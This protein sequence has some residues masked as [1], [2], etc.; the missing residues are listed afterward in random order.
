MDEEQGGH[1]EEG[2]EWSSP[3]PRSGGAPPPSPGACP[4]E[5]AL[6]SLWQG[7]MARYGQGSN[8]PVCWKAAPLPAP[9]PLEGSPTTLASSTAFHTWKTV[10]AVERMTRASMAHITVGCYC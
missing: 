8:S 4:W 1:L 7:A 5:A 10:S 6:E 2:E 3:A 9:Y